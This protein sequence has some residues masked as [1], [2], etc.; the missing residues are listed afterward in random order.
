VSA[1]VYAR[2]E[3]LRTF[4]NVRFFFFSLVF[5]LVMYFLIAGPNKNVH[6]LGHTAGFSGYF[7]PLYYMVSLAAWGAMMSVMAGGARI[8]AERSVGWNRQ[9][10]LTPLSTRTYFRAK[11]LTSYVLALISIGLLY[12]AGVMFGVRLPAEKWL[13]MTALI[14][15]AAIPFAAIGIFLGHVMSIDSMGP[16][17]GGITALFAFLGG[18]WFPITGGGFFKVLAKCLPSYWLVQAG[19]LGLGGGGQVW[20]AKGWLCIIAWTVVFAILAMKAY[21]RDTKRV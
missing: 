17:L 9:L 11:V 6:D 1:L 20:G 3:L 8:A 21:Q 13:Q 7:A 5:P 2:Y 16:A 18:V 15:V 19:R 10:R 4:R 14:L 12:L